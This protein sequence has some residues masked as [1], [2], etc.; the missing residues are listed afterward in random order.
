MPEVNEMLICLCIQMEM[1]LVDTEGVEGMQQ[2]TSSVI[3]NYV[4]Y[5]VMKATQQTWILDDFEHV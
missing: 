2:R 1:K 3:D 4:M 5:H